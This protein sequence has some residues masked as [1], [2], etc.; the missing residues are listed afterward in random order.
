MTSNNGSGRHPPDDGVRRL[1]NKLRSLSNTT[2]L[3]H[4]LMGFG[5]FEEMAMTRDGLLIGRLRRCDGF[6]VFIGSVTESMRQRT[7]RLWRELDHDER[8]LVLRRLNEQSIDPV[9]VGIPTDPV[10]AA[11]SVV[12]RPAAIQSA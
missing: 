11:A 5:H 8:Q 12:H 1:R 4:E 2:D 9:R 6:D 3:L 7:A 10:P